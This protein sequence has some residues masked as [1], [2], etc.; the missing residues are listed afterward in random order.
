MIS[1]SLELRDAIYKYCIQQGYS[2]YTHLPL[3]NENAPYPFVVVGERQTS[4]KPYKAMIGATIY[5]TLH[6]WGIE[7]DIRRV[8]EIM[9]NLTRLSFK[10]LRTTNYSFT[11]RSNLIDSRILEDDSVEDTILEHG[12]LTLSFSLQ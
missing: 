1:P 6:I 7:R 3:K 5:Q 8:D 10:T 4:N 12:I 11:G 9:C 2:V